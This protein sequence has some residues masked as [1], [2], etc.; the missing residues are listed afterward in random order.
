MKENINKNIK[1]GE[2]IIYKSLKG[3]EIQVKLDKNTVWLNAHLIADLFDVHRPAIVKHIN[4]IYKS[5]E[6]NKKT[7]CSKMEQLAADNKIRK[8]NLYNLDMIISV[9]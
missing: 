1:K 3:P 7:T 6:L 2:I 8:I 4:N 5:G 9:G